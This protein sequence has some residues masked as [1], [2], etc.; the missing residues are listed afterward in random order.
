ME[1]DGLYP[2]LCVAGS[3]A[4]GGSARH[5][6]EIV[7][8]NADAGCAAVEARM[9]WLVTLV[10]RP[11]CLFVLLVAGA[12]RQQPISRGACNL[13]ILDRERRLAPD[14]ELVGLN[15]NPA[16]SG[17]PLF[18]SCRIKTSPQAL[19]LNRPL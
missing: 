4:V 11:V 6:E 19:R 18:K 17:S 14:Q 5:L 10:F 8:K 3:V 15:C 13:Q 1:S 2:S 7:K 16:D 12:G 9:N